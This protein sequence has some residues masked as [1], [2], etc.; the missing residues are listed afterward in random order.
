MVTMTLTALLLVIVAVILV[1]KGVGTPV[2]AGLPSASAPGTVTA[3]ASAVYGIGAAIG[4]LGLLALFAL[5]ATWSY[6]LRGGQQGA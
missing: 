6:L 2:V 5:L 4:V 1:T 3:N